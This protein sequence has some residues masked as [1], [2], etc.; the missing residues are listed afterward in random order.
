AEPSSLE[1]IRDR[2]SMFSANFESNTEWL[3]GV[4]SRDG[5]TVLGGTGLHPRIDLTG[6]EIGYW[7]RETETG[8]GYAT[9]VASALTKCALS[10]P[11]IDHVEIRCDPNNVKSAG[12]PQRL[13]YAHV[14]TIREAGAAPGG[15]DRDTMIWRLDAEGSTIVQPYR[16]P[17]N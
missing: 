17:A 6:I 8:Q 12:I 14:G 5:V 4:F 16:R 15:A 11:H 3:Y 10:L 13:G 7:L 9:E 2:L 1:A